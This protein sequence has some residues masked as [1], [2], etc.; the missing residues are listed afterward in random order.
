MFDQILT[1]LTHLKSRNCTTSIRRHWQI[2]IPHAPPLVPFT[3][4]RFTIPRSDHT[5]NPRLALHPHPRSG[6]LIMT[7]FRTRFA[8]WPNSSSAITSNT[9]S[10]AACC[11]PFVASGGERAVAITGAVVCSS[12]CSNIF[13]TAAGSVTPTRRA[14]SVDQECLWLA[15]VLACSSGWPIQLPASALPTQQ[16]GQIDLSM[17][18]S[19][20]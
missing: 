3:Q 20:K 12:I 13:R 19:T 6:S 16:T 7:R 14:T 5:L 1:G 8:V 11:C 10:R 9:A 17:P 2:T 18:P 4:R 15:V